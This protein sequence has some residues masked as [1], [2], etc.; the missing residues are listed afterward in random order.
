M[1]DGKS[2]F[3]LATTW[4]KGSNIDLWSDECTK[5]TNSTAK[6]EALTVSSDFKFYVTAKQT[7]GRGRGE[8]RWISPKP[9]SA[10]LSSWSFRVK[11]APQHLSA[12]LFGLA[13]YQAAEQ[14]WPN[15]P[16]SLKAPNDLFLGD[17][18]VAGVLLESVSQGDQHRIIIGLGFNGYTAPKG[19]KN[20]TFLD[21]FT[22]ED[23]NHSNWTEFLTVLKA[24]F[25]L[26]A[27]AS[28][29]SELSTEN[30][31]DLLKALNKNP[32]LSEPYTAISKKGDL[33][34]LTATKAWSEL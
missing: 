21:D 16:W 1:S 31:S 20:A 7:A 6:D 15:A 34:S 22:H 19:V 32:L 26:A 17:K 30:Q 24:V 13:L 11:E 25:T 14:T 18:K 3:K 23:H 29:Q 10:L 8:N 33:V 4:A 2:I 12:P 27:E 9:G 28:S 5:N